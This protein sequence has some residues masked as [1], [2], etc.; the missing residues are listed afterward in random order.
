[1]PGVLGRWSTSLRQVYEAESLP[2]VLLALASLCSGVLILAMDSR[3]TFIADD[4]EFLVKRHGFGPSVYLEPFKEHFMLAPALIFKVFLAVFG[5][6]SARPYYLFSVALFLLSV[7]L[8]FVYLRRRVGG[9]LALLGAVSVLFLGA[10]FEDFLWISPMNYYGSMAAGLAMLLS[11]DRRDK[12]GDRMAC[13]ALMGSICFSSVGI[14]F[15]AGAVADIAIADRRPRRSR[16]YIVLLPLIAYGLWFLTWGH[17]AGGGIDISSIPHLPA[18]VFRAAAAGVTSALGLASNDGSEASQPH[19]IWGELVLIIA[20]AA[21][22]IR[23]A[24]LRRVPRN[25]WVVLAIAL[26]F[27]ILT[28]I[29]PNLPNLAH[30]AE[31]TA[32]SSRYQYISVVLLLLIG[33]ELLRD[34]RIPRW[35]PLAGAVVAGLATIGGISLMHREWKERWAPAADSLR[36]SLAAIEIA[37]RAAQP[38]FRVTFPPAVAVND[39]TYLDAVE[40]RGS[41]AFSEAELEERPES[42]RASADLTIA[43]ALGIS[44]QKPEPGAR[45]LQCQR[46][47]ASPEGHTGL[48]LKH[49]GF[50][51]RNLG[52]APIEVDL[53]RFSSGF[54]VSLGPLEPGAKA[55][56]S[57]PADNSPRPWSLGLLGSGA[58]RLCTSPHPGAPLEGGGA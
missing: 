18:Y 35:V 13:A 7:I 47:E 39:A 12:S 53:A 48:T 14:A 30:S 34:L 17:S 42:E 19:L 52:S 24:L 57:I 1:M 2:V 28:G 44:L 11:F 49:G 4:W 10:A 26:A 43:Q 8:A 21:G 55:A 20:I 45:T 51:L 40:E 23:L 31:H 58:V 9:W 46:L 32:T 41:P 37:G 29:K 56:V 27:W 25:L 16:L 15:A 38:A 5:L 36:S 22:A 50:V 6:Q 33:A 54:S 3:L